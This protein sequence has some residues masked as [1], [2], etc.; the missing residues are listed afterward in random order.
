MGRN[1][2][3]ILIAF[4]VL[5][6][7]LIFVYR[8]WR[9]R[10]AAQLVIDIL[11]T[12]NAISAKKAISLEEMGLS[13]SNII[14]ASFRFRDFRKDALDILVRKGIVQTTDELKYYVSEQTLFKTNMYRPI[15]PR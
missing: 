14:E 6:V 9:I 13:T 1:E 10:R 11:R 15:T 2:I 8:P 5:F 3:I 7:L 4:A 12:N